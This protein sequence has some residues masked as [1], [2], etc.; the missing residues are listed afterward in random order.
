MNY[1]DIAMP[2]QD[3]PSAQKKLP[4]TGNSSF[5]WMHHPK[6]WALHIFE[7]TKGDEVLEVP[8]WLPKFTTLKETAGVN[9]VVM[10]G[11]RPDSTHAQ[12]EFI[13]NGFKI[14]QHREHDYLRIY[15]CHG[16]KYHVHKWVQIEL[17]GNQILRTTDQK[18]LADFKKSLV[19]NRHV[20]IPHTGILRLITKKMVE[21]INRLDQKSHIPA[22]KKELQK[23]EHLLE[24]ARQA[25]DTL[26]KKGIKAYV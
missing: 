17:I 22:I 4:L 1:S 26:N 7:K 16:G 20:E 14:L 11:G 18:G 10:N 12:S 23:E 15:P 21:Q 2:W 24:L 19:K 9:N 5:L 8:L 3:A 6:N 13:R 25:T